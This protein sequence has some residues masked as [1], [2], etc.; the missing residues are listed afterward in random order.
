[1]LL[2]FLL[3][4]LHLFV[5]YCRPSISTIVI[6]RDIGNLVEN[7]IHLHKMPGIQDLRLIECELGDDGLHALCPILP[8]LPKL[9]IL[10]IQDNSFTARGALELFATLPR[11]PHIGHV[12]LSNNS[13]WCVGVAEAVLALLSSCRSL[14]VLG[15][16]RCGLDSSA[17]TSLQA[18]WE[19]PHRHPNALYL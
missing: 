19:A 7:H 3:F 18:A 9:Q 10:A 15:L 6:F 12:H 17:K 4:C 16:R 8:R 1:M 11:C 5:S 14:Q 2:S 13:I